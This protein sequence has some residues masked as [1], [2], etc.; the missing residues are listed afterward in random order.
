M[1]GEYVWRTF[2]AA[3]KRPPFVVDEC[4]EPV[5]QRVAASNGSEVPIALSRPS[6]K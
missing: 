4:A 1:V 3:R 6:S 5:H 2:D